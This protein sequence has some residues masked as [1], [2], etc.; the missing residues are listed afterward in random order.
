MRFTVLTLFPELIDTFFSHGMVGRA[1][2]NGIIF[3][4]TINIRDFA[5]NRHNSVDDRPYG[6]G[7]G[8]VMRPEPLAL[9]IKEA[10]LSSPESKVILMSP[11]GETFDQKI[12][13]QLAS[14]MQGLIFVCGRYEGIDE[15]VV[16]QFVDEELSIGDYVMTGGELA[17]MVIMDSV[18]RLLPGV[19]GGSESAQMDSFI[20]GRLEHAHYTRPPVFDEIAVPDILVGGNHKKIEEWREASSLKRTFLKRPDLFEK[21]GCSDQEKKLLKQWRCELKGWIEKLETLINQS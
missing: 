12:A 5:F 11:Q 18:I 16:A 10:K 3:G 13:C 9:A 14:A 4:T 6:G 15:R 7:C 21:D 17:S 1:I 8:M 20:N 2:A 19:L